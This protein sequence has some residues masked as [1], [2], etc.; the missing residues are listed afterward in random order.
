MLSLKWHYLA[1]QLWFPHP[2]C[3]FGCLVCS[4][5]ESWG[6][7]IAGN[8]LVS[9]TKQGFRKFYWCYP[10]SKTRKAAERKLDLVPVTPSFIVVLLPP[11]PAFEPRDICVWTTSFN[12]VPHLYHSSR[13]PENKLCHPGGKCCSDSLA[14]CPPL[15][16][17][18]CCVALSTETAAQRLGTVVPPTGML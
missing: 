5:Q 16:F 11:L 18:S 14:L 2:Q 13:R 9:Q 8:N 17:P 3:F 4:S 7:F 10:R 15:H 6:L 12:T 1:F